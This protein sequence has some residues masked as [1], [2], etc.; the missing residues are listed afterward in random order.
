MNPAAGNSTSFT[1]M[2]LTARSARCVTQ[3]RGR[4]LVKK[5]GLVVFDD[6]GWPSVTLA[7]DFL[8][9]NL[10]VIDEVFES[11]EA[12]YGAYEGRL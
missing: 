11:G 2:A 8:T 5:G 7:R 3:S 10:T 9:Q 12:S 1:S 4:S 6:I